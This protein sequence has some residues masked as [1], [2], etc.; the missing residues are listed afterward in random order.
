MALNMLDLPLSLS[1]PLLLLAVTRC[2]ESSQAS[3]PR[4]L[5]SRLLCPSL[6]IALRDWHGVIASVF[7]LSVHSFS[8]F[9]AYSLLLISAKRSSLQR[10]RPDFGHHDLAH[11]SVS[12]EPE[13]RRTW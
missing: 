10:R 2:L 13:I 12:S 11:P 7:L 4:L 1:L 3:R 5:R 9:N 6:F 8:K